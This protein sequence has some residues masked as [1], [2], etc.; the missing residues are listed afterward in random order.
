MT[1]DE[2]E[3]AFTVSLSGA[4]ER[5]AGFG[6]QPHREDRRYGR[7]ADG[8]AER[9]IGWV[10]GDS[11][12][13]TATLDAISG[14]AVTVSYGATPDTATSEDYTVGGSGT[15]TIPVGILTAS[16]MVTLCRR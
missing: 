3:E 2:D 8:D 13:F 6:K 7:P 12:T 9:S 15:L 1:L 5:H 11:L 4:V 10:R 14:R 16:F